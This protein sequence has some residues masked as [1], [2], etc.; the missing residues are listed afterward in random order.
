MRPSGATCLHADCVGELEKRVSSGV[1]SMVI[2]ST[3]IFFKCFKKQNVNCSYDLQWE[4][5]APFP[6]LHSYYVLSTDSREN[7]P[8]LV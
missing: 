2:K 6:Y 4:R 8:I 5:Q 1:A 7:T 3:T